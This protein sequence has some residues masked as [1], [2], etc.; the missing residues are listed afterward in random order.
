VR[1]K[2]KEPDIELML[3]DDVVGD[4]M[5]DL[6]SDSSR[7]LSVDDGDGTALMG[8]SHTAPDVHLSTRSSQWTSVFKHH[9][10]WDERFWIHHKVCHAG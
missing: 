8:L 2:G 6:V 7:E 4:L 5:H 10:R 1:V 3:G 9:H